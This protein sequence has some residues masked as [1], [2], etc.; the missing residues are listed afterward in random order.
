MSCV[1]FIP[2][3]KVRII[4][5]IAFLMTIPNIKS[6]GQVYQGLTYDEL[7]RPL[8]EMARAHNQVANSI[9]QLYSY[10]VD[11]LGHDIDSQLR[12][13]MNAELKTLDNLSKQLSGNGYSASISNGINSSYRRIQK[14]IANYN[15]RV[16]Q[17]KEQVA[18]EEAIRRAE[19]AKKA[20]EPEEWSGTGFALKDGYIATNYHVVE[21]ANRIWVYGVNG[22]TASGY[23]A[24]VVAVDKLNDLAIIRISDSRFSGF[25]VIP[26]AIKSQMVDVGE[27][28]WIL[29]YPLTQVLGNEVKLT[30]GLISSKSGYQGDVATYQISAP[31]QP[32]NS[33]GPLFDSK[34]N[35]VGI[36][37][38]GV[39]GAENVGYAIKTSYL[40]NLADSYSLS[41]VLPTS[42]SISS[43]ALKDQVKRVS[44]YVFMLKCSS[45][46]NSF[47]SSPSAYTTSYTS[48]A[49]TSSSER[50][51]SESSTMASS[52]QMSISQKEL[53]LSVGQSYTLAVSNYGTSVKWESMDP[54]VATV[55]STGKVTAIGVGRTSIWATGSEAKRC[56]VIVR[57]SSTS[58]P[59]FSSSSNSVSKG[60]KVEISGVVR[61]SHM[62]SLL[63]GAEVKVQGT[64]VRTN[65]S[66]RY[67][68]KVSPGDIIFFSDKYHETTTRT[69]DNSSQSINVILKRK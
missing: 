45:K 37:N 61:S 2:M 33:G 22:N 59:S 48:G 15:N 39:P 42:G 19:E 52:S 20:T 7:V 38:A 47:S 9:N 67:T 26:Y 35:V 46:A 29:G 25:G 12:K 60:P 31:V 14:S 13:E 43:L 68:I 10:V 53:T 16:A 40:R 58:S 8:Q 51:S 18:K 41:T 28:I 32:G 63:I 36:V 57:D 64:T 50:T 11:V 27:D 44:N 66:G 1:K 54:R 30:N 69:V 34:G 24:N 62:N 4:A 56:I 21:R 5:L 65:S 55:S 23:T 6:N 49:T 3:H 17:Y